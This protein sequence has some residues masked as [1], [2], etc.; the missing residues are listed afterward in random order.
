MIRTAIIIERA[1]VALGGAE[2]SVFELA[3]QLRTLGVDAEI[4]AA[5]GAQETAQVKV[6]C[7]QSRGKRTSFRDFGR[8]LKS[9]LAQTR[10]DVV[11]STLPFDFADIYQPRGGSYAEASERNIAS[12]DHRAV[13]FCKTA[14]QH[15]NLRRTVLLNAEKRLCRPQRRTI[16]A[17]LS[18]YV[19]SQFMRHY[20]VAESRIRV[21]GN[22]VAMH[23]PPDPVQAEALRS[24]ILG[25]LGAGPGGQPA[26]F[27]FAAN[28]FRLK[29]LGAIVRAL[30]LLKGGLEPR[31]VY[32]AV[33]GSGRTENYRALADELGVSDRLVFLGA[34]SDVHQ[35]LAAADAAVLPTYYDPCSRFILEALTHARPVITT[36]FNGAAERYVDRRHGAVIDDPRDTRALAEAFAW[37]ADVDNARSA[38]E[39]IRR[40]NLAENIS[41][42]RHAEMLVELYRFIT[43]INL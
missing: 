11:H 33:A 16:I 6:L 40:D 32:V 26:V 1:D 27:L 36:R 3:G 35:A 4:L 29:G 18:E 39:A 43:G 7:G 30:A 14:T 22:G 2:R 17:A 5:T 25:D 28:N 23:Q 42:A 34:L 20:N 8:A 31:P 10:Y 13:R 37:V 9:H 41:I 38:A 21:I 15:F 12:Y 24:R 19:K